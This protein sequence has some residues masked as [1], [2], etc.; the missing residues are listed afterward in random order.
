MVLLGAALGLLTVIGGGVL[1]GDEPTI[2]AAAVCAA[3]G[4]AAAGTVAVGRSG[5]RRRGRQVRSA[6]SPQPALS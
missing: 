4:A 6:A 2:V 1:G 3:L 5:R